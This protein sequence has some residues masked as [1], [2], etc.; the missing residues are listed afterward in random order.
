MNDFLISR[1]IRR[2]PC[3]PKPFG[4]SL[5]S[6]GYK[7]DQITS[8]QTFFSDFHC[9]TRIIVLNPFRGQKKIP[10]QSQK[11]EKATQ[12]YCGLTALQIYQKLP[13]EKYSFTRRLLLPIPPW[14]LSA[15]I[16]CQYLSGAK[17]LASMLILFVLNLTL[18]KTQLYLKKPYSC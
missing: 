9:V 10:K 5:L 18:G 15:N 16:Y 2:Y 6:A 17:T 13:T 8:P 4:I 1:S 11:P 14:K 3:S 7:D 12:S